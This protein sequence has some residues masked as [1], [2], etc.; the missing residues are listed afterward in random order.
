M[1]KKAK[2][3]RVGVYVCECGP[4]IA[5]AV[6][7]DAILSAVS[8]SDNVVVAQRFKLLCTDEGK[9][10]LIDEIAKYGLTHLVVGACSPKQEEA[11][12]MSL[13]EQAGINPY[14]FQMANIREHVAWVTPDKQQATERAIRS[15][16][17]AIYRVQYHSPLEKHE[18]ECNADVLVI[19][20]GIAGM[21]AALL[22]AEPERMVYLVEKEE[23]LGGALREYG[24]LFP[25]MQNAPDRIHQYIE[26]IETNSNINVHTNTKIKETRGFLGNFEVVLENAESESRELKVGAIVVALGMNRLNPKELETF[27]YGRIQNVY[28][29][30]EAEAMN[31]KG[32]FVLNDGRTPEG[33]AIVHCIGRKQKGYCSNV[34]CLAGIKIASYLKEK[35]ADISITSFYRDLCL[36]G[37]QAQRLYEE[38]RKNGVNFKCVDTVTVTESDGKIKIGYAMP[39]GSNKEMNVDMVILLPSIEPTT[40]TADVAQML[41]IP[42]GPHGFLMEEHEKLRPVSTSIDGIYIAGCVSGPKDI[43]ETI[44]QAEAAAGRIR[45]GLVPGRKLETEA[46]VSVIQENVCAGCRTC[47]TVCCYSAIEY[48]QTKGICVV[49]EV[50]CRGCG[51]C[52]SA[53]PSGA[54]IHQHFTTRQVY[55][56][57]AG[58]LK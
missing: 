1:E 24:K 18:I 6:D 19:G 22:L 32:K 13:C 5:N 11:T 41:N 53:C 55:R 56:E 34:C 28:S 42:I 43:A 54:A 36:P 51:N 23:Q 27:G 25:T 26:R 46:K 49:N 29:A 35:K 9:K 33:V 21:S 16:R 3:K 10:F 45:A 17:A 30:R 50:L 44:S 37:C 14:M 4:N 8:G 58:I 2:E 31:L 12:F 15:I 52:A 47:M 40:D 20:G 57:I 38:S 48:D 39:D 7:I